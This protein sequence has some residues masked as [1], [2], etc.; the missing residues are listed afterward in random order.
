MKKK[1]A[2]TSIVGGQRRTGDGAANGRLRSE[3]GRGQDRER[4]VAGTRK[5]GRKEG[6]K[7][8]S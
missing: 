7:D 8:R 6:M 2:R 5:D 3:S 4:S 1:K